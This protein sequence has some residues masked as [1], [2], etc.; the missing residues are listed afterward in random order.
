M[1]TSEETAK[2]AVLT[3]RVIWEGDKYVARVNELTLEGA[4]D[5]VG[6]ARATM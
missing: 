5:S 3:A 1:E 6:E 4:G 2:T